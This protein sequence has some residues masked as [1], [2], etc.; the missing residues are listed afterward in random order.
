MYKISI[1]D[2]TMPSCS[3]GVA[4]YYVDNIQEFQKRWFPLL[5]SEE[6]KKRF[7]RS[8][9]G[10]VM[11][12]CYSDDPK[13]N[14]VQEDKR[15]H[16]YAEKE[17][18]IQNNSFT[19]INAYQWESKIWVNDFIANIRWVRYE[20]HFL[21]LVKFKAKGIATEGMIHKFR[22]IKCY[23]NPVLEQTITSSKNFAENIDEYKN[24]VVESIA[25]YPVNVF[26]SEEALLKNIKNGKL[27]DKETIALIHSCVP[28]EDMENNVIY[29]SEKEDIILEYPF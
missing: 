13:L 24:N 25:Y 9:H 12:D 1:F 19:A 8:L 5:K 20:N 22:E 11:V 14:M 16:I 21:K 27:T 15:A 2:E 18:V 29:Q 26:E 23:G 6:K 4:E 3:S 17:L 7:I 28:I 10:E